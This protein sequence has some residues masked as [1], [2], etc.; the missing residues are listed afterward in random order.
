MFDFYKTYNRH[1]RR[2]NPDPEADLKENQINYLRELY[3]P[4]LPRDRSAFCLDIGCGAGVFLSFLRSEGYK[5]LHGIDFSDDMIKMARKKLGSEVTVET[6]EAEEYLESCNKSFHFISM[7][8]LIEHLTKDKALR[9]IKKIYQVLDD[10][11]TFLCRTTNMSVL[12]SPALFYSDIT[13]ITG[14]SE[15]SLRQ[16]LE[17]VGFHDITILHPPTPKNLKGKLRYGINLAVHKFLYKLQQRQLPLVL[18]NNIT[19]MTRKSKKK[20]A[21]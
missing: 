3:G 10:D 18:G 7:I 20:S 21:F 6:V 4:A 14:Y 13:H 12:L 5:N 15:Y 2:W 1:W 16:L 9:V 17:T 19:V 11:G 8:D